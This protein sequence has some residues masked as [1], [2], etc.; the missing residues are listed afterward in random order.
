MTF[1]AKFRENYSLYEIFD[2]DFFFSWKI[3]PPLHL[4]LKFNVR[5]SF[6]KNYNHD[7]FEKKMTFS[8]KKSHGC[9]KPY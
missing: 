3:C 5:G 1:L 6:K 8:K 2:D 7:F 4:R 9:E